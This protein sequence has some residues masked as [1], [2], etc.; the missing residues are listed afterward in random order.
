MTSVAISATAIDVVCVLHYDL[1]LRPQLVIDYSSGKNGDRPTE[2]PC[3]TAVG[4]HI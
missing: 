4:V 2:T 3:A 1:A